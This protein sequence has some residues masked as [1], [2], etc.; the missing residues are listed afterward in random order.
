[1]KNHSVTKENRKKIIDFFRLDNLYFQL[2]PENEED[3]KIL[4]FLSKLKKLQ[5]KTEL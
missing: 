3:Q 2:I 1:M 4:I 5:T